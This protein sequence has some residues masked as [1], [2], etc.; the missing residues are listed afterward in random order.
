MNP[1]QCLQR[2]YADRDSR[3]TRLRQTPLAAKPEALLGFQLRH[4]EQEAQHLEPVA[5][6]QPRQIG[7]GLGNEG[8]GLIRPT[9]Q[10]RFIVA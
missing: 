1:L 7:R 8:R 6:R 5:P 10:T 9:I 2:N 3:H 4:P